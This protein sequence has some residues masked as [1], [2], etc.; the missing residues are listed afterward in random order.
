M[1]SVSDTLKS[2]RCY[3]VAC[4]KWHVTKGS[5]WHVANGIYIANCM[6]WRAFHSW[7]NNYNSCDDDDNNKNKRGGNAALIVCRSS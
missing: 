6:F 5:K 4:S 2:S 3:K 7:K 1:E